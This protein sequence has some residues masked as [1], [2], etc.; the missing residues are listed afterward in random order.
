METTTV[1]AFAVTD[2]RKASRQAKNPLIIS[3]EALE[4]AAAVAGVDLGLGVTIA[5]RLVDQSKTNE[6][7]V[8]QQVGPNTY[9]I[10]VAVAGKPN[11]AFTRAEAEHRERFPDEDEHY[12]L[13]VSDLSVWVAD[14]FIDDLAELAAAQ[15]GSAAASAVELL[16]RIAAAPPAD[17]RPSGEEPSSSDYL[18]EAIALLH[19]LVIERT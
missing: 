18:A 11:Y 10:T 3:T 1:S 16:A 4:I 14:D 13:D 15:P 7:G 6:Q 2:W 19:R 17:T 9:R 5:I 8:A 12:E